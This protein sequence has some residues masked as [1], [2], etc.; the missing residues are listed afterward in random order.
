MKKFTLAPSL[1]AASLL[2]SSIFLPAVAADYK[3]DHEGAHASINFT[4]SHLGFSVLTGR[5]N[6]FSGNFSYDDKDITAAKISVTVDTSSFDS[7]H[8]LRDKHV[9]SDDFLDVTKFA[10]ARFDSNKVEDKGNGSLLISG[11]FTLHGVTKPMVIDAIKIGEGNDPWGG[12]RLGFSGTSTIS[13][14]D[15]G[16]KKDFGKIELA[17]HIEGIRQ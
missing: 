1:L 7:N 10:Q 2:T 17:L 9:R 6:S 12:Y 11:D 5:F 3:I 13:M 16:F 8:A 14:A 15:F 4:A